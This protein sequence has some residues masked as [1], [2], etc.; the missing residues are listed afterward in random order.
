[1]TNKEKYFCFICDELLTDENSSLEHVILNACGGKLKST[2]LLCKGCNSKI[3]S[4]AD[5]ELSEQLNFFSTY[6]NVDRDRGEPQKIKGLT[7]K[8][9]N[10]YSLS[11]GEVNEPKLSRPSVE[12]ETNGDRTEISIM[13]SDMATIDKIFKDLNKKYPQF[14][15]TEAKKSLVESKGYVSDSLKFTNKIG[16][17]IA[18]RS[19]VK[20]GIEFFILSGGD[21]KSIKHLIP[22]ITGKQNLEII[23]FAHLENPY[24]LEN[25]EISHFL[26]VKADNKEKVIWAFVDFFNAYS[27]FICLNDNYEG[28][29]FENTY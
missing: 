5:S 8:D 19:I 18:F 25:K 7:D 17:D 22:Y 3:G 11:P 9:G 29:N 12:K 10:D 16:G 27:Y 23:W 15:I 2:K 4:K 21:A 14:N 1:M 24:I 13:A 6:V 28:K 26:H 20:T